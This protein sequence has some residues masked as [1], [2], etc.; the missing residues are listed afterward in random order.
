MTTAPLHRAGLL[1][2]PCIQARHLLIPYLETD[3]ESSPCGNWSLSSHHERKEYFKTFL[4]TALKVSLKPRDTKGF[5]TP[6]FRHLL[7]LSL[8]LIKCT[9]SYIIVNRCTTACAENEVAAAEHWVSL[10]FLN[11]S[12]NFYHYFD[13]SNVPSFKKKAKKYDVAAKLLPSFFISSFPKIQMILKSK[14]AAFE[15]QACCELWYSCSIRSC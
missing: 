10:A 14:K 5:R 3:L 7:C 12:S 2:N 9:R 13:I 11:F 4:K 6:S 8:Q 15:R 1:W